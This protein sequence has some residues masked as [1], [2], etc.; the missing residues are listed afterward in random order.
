MKLRNC[1][2]LLV[3]IWLAATVATFARVIR[4]DFDHHADFAHYKTYS[5]KRV[6]T[7]DPFWYDRVKEA[8]NKVLSAK[9]W[10]EVPS[11]GDVAIVVIAT[12]H[13]KPTLETLYSGFGWRWQGFGMATTTVENY[14]VGTLIVDIFDTSEK[15]LIWRGSASEVL[16]DKPEKDIKELNKTVEKMFEH[17]PPRTWH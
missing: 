16:P 1:C 15:K 8:I 7:T 5:W 6:E 13:R 17:F 11:E 9:G 3:G 14:R 10:T 2:L 12:T 4:T